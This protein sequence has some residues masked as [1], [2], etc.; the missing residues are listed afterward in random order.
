MPVYFC[1]NRS[2]DVLKLLKTD[3]MDSSK[4]DFPIMECG[5]KQTAIEI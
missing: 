2:K 5:Y 1:T 3:N 4:N